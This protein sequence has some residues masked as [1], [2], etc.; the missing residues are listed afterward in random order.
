MPGR[1]GGTRTAFT[2]NEDVLLVKYIAT[3]NPSLRGRQGQLL[4]QSL[5]ANADGKWN[6]S[7]THSWQSWRERYKNNQ[8]SFDS[9]IRKYQQKHGIDPN[10]TP[11]KK[12]KKAS[13]PVR[14]PTAGPS[15][16]TQVTRTA[17]ARKE[18][19]DEESESD[20]QASG[21]SVAKTAVA[22]RPR[23][24]AGTILPPMKKPRLTDNNA[25]V[26]IKGK[27]KARET[28]PAQVDNSDYGGE[29]DRTLNAAGDEFE[30]DTEGATIALSR[31]SAP[32]LVH[33]DTP[34]QNA[35]VDDRSR[36]PHPTFP[37]VAPL[38]LQVS[39]EPTP[40]R[41]GASVTPHAGTPDYTAPSSPALPT[42]RHTNNLTH[43]PPAA[44]LKPSR[45]KPPRRKPV[46]GNV[47]IFADTPQPPTR[48]T[49]PT[50]PPSLRRPREPPRG[51][52][53][54][55]VSSFTDAQGRSRL[56]AKGGRIEADESDSEEWPPKRRKAGNSVVK[57]APNGEITRAEQGKTGLVEKA[58][59]SVP[60]PMKKRAQVNAK[61]SSSKVMLPPMTILP[62]PPPGPALD[63]TAPVPNDNNVKH[64]A[65]TVTLLPPP[66]P[67][68][69]R[70]PSRESIQIPRARSVMSA[71]DPFSDNAPTEAKGKQRAQDRSET[72]LRRQTFGGQEVPHI[73]LREPRRG[74]QRQ[75]L[76]GPDAIV[77]LLELR[78]RSSMSRAGTSRSNSARSRSITA[79]HSR[80]NSATDSVADSPAGRRHSRAASHFSGA[81]ASSRRRRSAA[82]QLLLQ[83]MI[84]VQGMARIYGFQEDVVR[85]V[86]EAAGGL[87]A[88][89][90]ILLDMKEEATKAFQRRTGIAVEEEA[91]EAGDAED[92][93][94][95]EH[96][97]EEDDSGEEAQDGD[98]VAA[99]EEEEEEEAEEEEEEEEEAHED[100]DLAE[101]SQARYSVS[102]PRIR[103]ESLAPTSLAHA[104]SA[105]PYRKA[106]SL[107]ITPV[108]PHEGKRRWAGE[109]GS[110]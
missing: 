18:E 54:P 106:P 12:P 99:A 84:V 75:S 91:D 102:S 109:N 72:N 9:K 70:T 38:P 25:P 7:N 110:R 65:A 30:D 22:K 15:K 44:V 5:V 88:A 80:F 108:H 35:T 100:E 83:D 11:A 52:M 36:K 41:S 37:K 87:D 90:R 8:P 32:L 105:S 19:E 69:S 45:P 57:Q 60:V 16:P 67:L 51:E 92:H 93:G 74:K 58:A 78:K 103:P 29:F 68:A 20:V 82:D 85:N 107:H 76:P 101:P 43:H 50:V 6:W 10:S 97:T 96:D 14:H 104:G 64:S 21:A 47:G 73:D 62:P 46:G 56:T 86:I 89:A 23:E 33:D 71:S 53:G 77:D 63:H 27:G 24:S 66:N 17:A 31:P 81:S 48:T 61:A 2:E 4:Y 34:R 59:P 94:T 39:Q 28:E 40:P 42:G 98:P 1:S 79:S 49:T 26:S 3:Y 13:A 55:Y 95:E